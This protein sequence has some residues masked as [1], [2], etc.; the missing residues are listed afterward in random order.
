MVAGSKLSSVLIY[1]FEQCVFSINRQAISLKSLPNAGHTEVVLAAASVCS[2]RSLCASIALSLVAPTRLPC[3]LSFA[4]T[5]QEGGRNACTIVGAELHIQASLE[6]NR[7]HLACTVMAQCKNRPAP[8]VAS[9]V[10]STARQSSSL[11]ALLSWQIY[12]VWDMQ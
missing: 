4:L 2:K 12:V 11:S 6:L 7:D 3:F 9:R 1:T 10:N 8:H 5:T